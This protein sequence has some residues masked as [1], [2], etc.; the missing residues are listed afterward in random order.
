MSTGR[1]KGQCRG[2]RCCP[3]MYDYSVFRINRLWGQKTVPWG[4]QEKIGLR[5]G[6]EIDRK[7]TRLNSSHLGISYAV[8]CFNDT[9]TTDIYTLS[10]HDALPIF[11][12][13]NRLWGQKTVPWGSQEKIG[14]RSGWEI[15]G[16]RCAESGRFWIF[17]WAIKSS[18][19]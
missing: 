3:Q 10:L 17:A 12:R 7:S 1:M 13:I 11:F 4:S 15:L 9:A 6:W 16:L 8:F 18:T 2:V 19:A 5:S 14:L